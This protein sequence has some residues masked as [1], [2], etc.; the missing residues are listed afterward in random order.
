MKG[1]LL[2]N[3][4]SPDSTS[5]KDVRKYL[6]E[7]LMDEYVIDVPYLLR[8]FLIECIILPF[9][10]KKSAE[11]YSQIW[12]KEGSPLV[13]ISKRVAEKVKQ[14]TNISVALAMRYGNPSIKN[15]I[16]ELVN[17]GVTEILVYS[18]YPHYAMS[19]TKTVE[20]K[21]KDIQQKL[22][23]NITLQFNKPFYN[24]PNYIKALSTSIKEHLP[25]EFDCLLF[26]YHGLPERHIRKTDPNGTCKLGNCCF[27]EDLPSHSTCYRHQTYKTTELVRQELDL[28]KAKIYQSFQSRLGNDP[29]LK[30]ATDKIFEEFPQKGKKKIAVVAPAFVSD[31]LETLEELQMRGKEDFMAAGGEEFIYI[32]C[33]NESELWIDFLIEEISHF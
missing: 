20:E 4:G 8:K 13:T 15:G 27:G 31:C 10:P 28:P 6:R 24:K 22:Y 11:A 16:K 17:Q 1:I 29:W 12:W 26:S 18:L 7:F 19:S 33:M 2:V 32:P 25:S 3:L 21:A 14:K 23:P 30:P 5:V 9:R